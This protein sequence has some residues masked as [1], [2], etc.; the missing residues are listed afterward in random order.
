[1]KKLFAAVFLTAMIAIAYAQTYPGQVP[2]NTVLGNS[3]SGTLPFAVPGP[4]INGQLANVAAGIT[5][6]RPI[7]AGTGAPQDCNLQVSIASGTFSDFSHDDAPAIQSALNAVGSGGWVLLNPSQPYWAQTAITIPTGVTLGCASPP[8][9]QHNSGTNYTSDG[10][11]IYL[12]P[13]NPI[14]NNGN[15]INA[16]I[17]QDNIHFAGQPATIHALKTITLNFASTGTGVINAGIDAVIQD[18][19]IAGFNLGISDTTTNRGSIRHVLIETQN[20]IKYGTVGDF[21]KGLDIECWP[22]YSANRDFFQ[23]G[24]SNI[25]NNGS[26]LWRIT[27]SSALTE[28][29]V[30]GDEYYIGGNGAISL[31]QGALG[32]HIITCVDSTHVDE[33]DSQVS[34]NPTGTTT[35]GSFYVTGLSSLNGLFA[36][37]TFTGTCFTGTR[38]VKM[39]MPTESALVSDAAATSTGSCSLTF[40][41]QA[42]SSAGTPLLMFDGSGGQHGIGIEFTGSGFLANNVY[43]WAHDTAFQFDANT[44]TNLITNAAVDGSTAYFR[45]DRV[46]ILF[47]GGSQWNKISGLTFTSGG[48]GVVNKNAINSATQGNYVDLGRMTQWWS[49]GIQN[50]NGALNVS[51]TADGDNPSVQSQGIGSVFGI[52]TG[53]LTLSNATLFPS[54]SFLSDNGATNNTV[55]D[56]SSQ[57]GNVIFKG[58]NLLCS[59]VPPT[60]NLFAALMSGGTPSITSCSVTGAGTGAT[61]VPAT[62]SSV[63]SF[64]FFITAGTTPASSGTVTANFA[65]GFTG[66]APT[67]IPTLDDSNGL[68]ST[69]AL[70]PHLTA[71]SNSAVTFSWNNNGTNL[72]NGTNYRIGVLCIGK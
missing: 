2:A 16:R 29:C 8:E 40:A 62:G 50:V 53:A 65:S 67:C 72:T 70:P 48:V 12:A 69:T 1:M 11:A 28:T 46:G 21:L 5:K 71:S 24:I 33:S 10:C 7:G 58:G 37:E 9:K 54:G 59:N 20:C 14:T 15:L 49:G 55:L 45:K 68:W 31:P 30:N 47:L 23:V 52:S 36:G 25:A 44:N 34:P 13:N 63:S 66:S 18:V 17:Y 41:S 35:T 64:G 32:N 39:L 61:C 26:G 22:F 60:C 27:L 51:N 57:V 6:C 38:T 4:V 3:T 43:V 56:P 19:A 42:F